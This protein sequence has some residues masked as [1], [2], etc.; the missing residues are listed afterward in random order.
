MLNSLGGGTTVQITIKTE[1]TN[2]STRSTDSS[3]SSSSY[4][5]QQG[6]VAELLANLLT[7]LLF[8]SESDGS[9]SYDSQNSGSQ[10]YGIQNKDGGALFDQNGQLTD[11][12]S[13]LG[14]SL[15]ALDP[16]AQL[17][18]LLLSALSNLL[19]TDE[20]QLD[21]SNLFGQKQPND[22]EVSAYNQGVQDVLN[23]LLNGGLKEASSN[24]TPL[25]LDDKGLEGLNGASDFN[26]L[27]TQIGLEVGQKAGLEALNNIGYDKKDNNNQ[28]NRYVIDKEDRELAAQIG[29]F[30]D[31]YPEKFGVPQYQ[32]K[33]WDAPQD[34]NKT[35]AQTLGNPGKDGMTKESL[36]KFL[37]A[38]GMVKSAVAGDTGNANLYERGNG[39]NSIGI[40]LSMLGDS[41]ISNELKKLAD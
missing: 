10:N 8:G 32:K 29:Q 18:N 23:L 5:G 25:Q 27:G 30:M 19:D 38:V 12:G 24:Q 21:T 15:N 11:T 31:Q 9:K 39:G 33:D 4:D 26:Q 6:D 22:E 36:N 7:S 28:Y 13:M 20:D 17:G 37:E 34:D 3:Q 16:S 40:D 35:W 2:Q 1:G 41:I 14:A